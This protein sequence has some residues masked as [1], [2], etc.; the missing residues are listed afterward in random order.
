MSDI[1]LQKLCAIPSAGDSYVR[2]S[3]SGA[4]DGSLLFLFI[5]PDGVSWVNAR[6]EQGGGIFPQP[7]MERPYHFRL[8][9]V[10]TDGTVTT[11]S[12]P[13]LDLTFPMVD[14]FPDGRI[15]LAGPRCSWRSE[16][17]VD[18]NGAVIDPQTGAVSR[19]LLGDGI[20]DVFI[21][22]RGRIWVSYFDEGV[23]G[24]FGWNDPGP[25]PTGSSGLMVFDAAG[26]ILWTY[27]WQGREPA[28]EDCYAMNVSGDAAAIYFYSTFP[29]CT[30][31]RDFALAFFSTPVRGCHAFALAG[32]NVLFSGQYNDSAHTGYRGA[33]NPDRAAEM[34]QVTFLRPD[35]AP[36]QAAR[37]VGRG[38]R[39]YFF[40][41][42]AVFAADLNGS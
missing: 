37:I 18:R 6:T 32:D 42:D 19:I 41:E 8:V 39:L 3:G 34:E 28:I 1:V 14:V 20:E 15:L 13:Q 10:A 35:G 27:P 33:L 29:V 4:A 26:A 11:N 30:V 25:P 9:R 31:T 23:F 40:A 16:T 38:S 7:R 21:D 22:T 2:I 17:D 12:L 5:E 24:E 36:V